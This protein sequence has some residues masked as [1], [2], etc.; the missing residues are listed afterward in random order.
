MIKSFKIQLIIKNNILKLLS[1]LIFFIAISSVVNAANP[2]RIAYLSPSFD[3][4]DAWERVYWAI[5]GRL[6]ELGVKYEIQALAVASCR[7]CW[8]TCTS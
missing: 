8:P 2:M 5:Q 6:D 4:S 1:A 3:V 7:P